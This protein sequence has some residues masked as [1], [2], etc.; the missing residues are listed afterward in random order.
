MHELGDGTLD[1]GVAAADDS[2]LL[3][4]E[5]AVVTRHLNGSLDTLADIDDDQTSVGGLTQGAEQPRMTGGVATAEGAHDDGLQAGR[6][7][8]MLQDVATHAGEQRDDDDIGVEGIEGLHGTAVVGTE[9]EVATVGDIDSGMGKGWTVEGGEGAESLGTLLGGA[10]ATQQTA[11]EIDAY[12][13]NI[14]TAITIAGSG[15]GDGGDEVLLAI[16]A[17]LTDGQLGTGEDDG[18]GEVAEHIGEGGGSVGHGVGAVEDDEA[19]VVLIARGDDAGKLLPLG[20]GDIAGVDGGRELTGMDVGIDLAQLRDMTQEMGEIE[21]LK[22]SSDG[23][24][25]HADGAAGID[26][27]DRHFNLTISR[28]YDF[29]ISIKTPSLFHDFTI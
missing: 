19:V 6:L 10:V 11:T 26:E 4:M 18:L 3:E 22:G 24:A 17:Q 8:D 2:C 23:I 15:Y 28:F 14:G 1:G 7:Q 12:L 27:K 16:G 5:A 20:R 29:T 21:G 25:A 13:G 9:D